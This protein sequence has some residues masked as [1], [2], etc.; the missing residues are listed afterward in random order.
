MSDDE[1]LHSAARAL[2]RA[3]ALQHPEHAWIVGVRED[4]GVQPVG[5][6]GSASSRQ[7]Q[8]GTVTDYPHAIRKGGS[9][10]SPSGPLDQDDLKKSA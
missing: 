9:A 7:D 3:L 2:E 8:A 4:D 5:N 1:Y 6:L 10:A